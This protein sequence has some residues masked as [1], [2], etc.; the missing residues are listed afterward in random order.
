VLTGS[1]PRDAHAL[2]DAMK[3]QEVVISAIGRG[4]SFKAEGLIAG[5]VP[6][7]LAAMAASAVRRLIFVSAIG[8]G[9]ALHDTPIF[10]RLFIKFMLKDIYADKAIGE[11]LVRRSGTDW[12]IVQPAQLFDGPLTGTYRS[13]ERLK[14]HGRPK[15]SRADVAHYVVAQVDDATSIGK[16]VRLDG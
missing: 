16:I 7:I 13:G 5:C 4:Q 14:Y 10:S 11:E 9:D 3:G 12:T 1:L 15:I 2:T 8:V 6:V